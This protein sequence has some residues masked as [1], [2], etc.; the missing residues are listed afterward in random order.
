M[1][2]FVAIAVALFAISMNANA[3]DGTLSINI[4]FAPVG[5]IH[6]TISLKPEKYKYDYNSYMNFNLG[7]EKQFKGVTTLSEFK[8]AQG[9]FDSYDLVGNSQ[10]FNPKLT[11]DVF[12]VSF[13]QYFGKTINPNKR[14]QFPLYIGIGGEYLKGGPFHNLILDGAAKARVKFFFTNHIGIFAGGTFRLGLGAKS[15]SESSNR[16]KDMYSILNT[17]WSVDAGLTYGL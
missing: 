4:G 7:I 2:K 5:H 14:I 8:Y 6:E 15:A 16:N 9:K 12:S 10:W 13:T 1:K 11:D 3:G 17:Q